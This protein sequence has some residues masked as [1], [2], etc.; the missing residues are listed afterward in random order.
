MTHM[1][2][3]MSEQTPDPGVRLAPLTDAARKQ[4][5]LIRR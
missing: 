5:G 1:T 4:Y 3:A 2:A